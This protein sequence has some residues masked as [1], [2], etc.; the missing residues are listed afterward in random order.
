MQSLIVPNFRSGD[1]NIPSNY[2]TIIISPFLANFYGIVLEKK[3]SLW[4]ESH[5]KRDKGQVS[6]TRYHS[7]VDHLVIVRITI[8]V[9]CNN[10]IDL[11][12]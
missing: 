3:I 6:F 11:L 4:I 1:R 9:Y 5:G 7:I 8:E 12:C 10:K 2:R